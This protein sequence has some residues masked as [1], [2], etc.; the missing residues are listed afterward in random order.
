[1]NFLSLIFVIVTISAM[2]TE[3]TSRCDSVGSNSALNI[4]S[5]V[6]CILKSCSDTG[7]CYQF[8]LTCQGIYFTL[9]K[10][11]SIYFVLIK[12]KFKAKTLVILLVNK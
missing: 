12:F 11:F 9:S 3:A 4:A 10:V 7:T 6:N 5:N 8:C 1:M 2:N